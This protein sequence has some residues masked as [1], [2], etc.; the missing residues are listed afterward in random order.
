MTFLFSACWRYSYWTF[1]IN[2]GNFWEPSLCHHEVCVLDVGSDFL[3]LIHVQLFKDVAMNLRRIFFVSSGIILNWSCMCGLFLRW[4]FVASIFLKISYAHQAT[5]WFIQEREKSKNF[6]ILFH[7]LPIRTRLCFIAISSC[8]CNCRWAIAILLIFLDL[9]T[10]VHI[11]RIQQPYLHGI[12]WNF[13][14]EHIYYV[15]IMIPTN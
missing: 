10:I 6:T 2:V 1:G 14:F 3:S 12:C 4:Q 5:I 7:V 15:W 9:Y 13:P 11:L 8:Y